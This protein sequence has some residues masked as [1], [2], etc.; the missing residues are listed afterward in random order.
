ML[1]KNLNHNRTTSSNEKQQMK[2]NRKLG[3]LN[4][5]SIQLK[6]SEMSNLID[7]NGCDPITLTATSLKYKKCFVLHQN[8]NQDES[9]LYRVVYFNRDYGADGKDIILHRSLYLLDPLSCSGCSKSTIAKYE[10]SGTFG[11]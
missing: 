7:S 8:C 5:R 1:E 3:I 6:A 11:R 9:K 4:C 2:I 10:I